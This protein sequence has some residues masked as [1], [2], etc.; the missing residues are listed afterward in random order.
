MPHSPNASKSRRASYDEIARVR[1]FI[2]KDDSLRPAIKRAVLYISKCQLGPI[3]RD[4]TGCAFPSVEAYMNACDVRDRRN[5]IRNLH[6]AAAT[7]WLERRDGGRGNANHWWTLMPPEIETELAAGKVPQ[8]GF[9]PSDKRSRKASRK[10]YRPKPK[11]EGQVAARP[12][13]LDA[14]LAVILDAA[15][16]RIDPHSARRFDASDRQ[17][18]EAATPAKRRA[19]VK[20]YDGAADLTQIN[21]GPLFQKCRDIGI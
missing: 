11:A 1:A 17:Q 15:M 10:E 18:I 16:A 4:L 21:L 9:D 12:N 3:S 6:K 13:A 5:A 19:F 8:P 14:R 7:K 20:F 2:A